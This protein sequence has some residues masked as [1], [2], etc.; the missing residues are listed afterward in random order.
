MRVSWAGARP[1]AVRL[2]CW[3][4][5]AALAAGVFRAIARAEGL[6]P[7]AKGMAAAAAVTLLLSLVIP[8]LSIVHALPG[9]SG[10]MEDLGRWGRETGGGL[11]GS[12]LGIAAFALLSSRAAIPAALAS[13]VVIGAAAV[14]F[15]ALARALGKLVR[16]R[17]AAGCAS[18]AALLAL[19][20]VPFWSGSLLR[21]SA[22][23]AWGKWL[24]GASPYLAAAL[25][26]TQGSVWTYDPRLGA[27]YDTW[28]GTDVPLAYPAWV[29]CAI[30]HLLAGGLLLTA[31][32]LP[33]LVRARLAS[34]SPTA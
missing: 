21:T 34:R 31:A 32:E 19:E 6:S 13:L 10:P 18:A 16:S 27:L 14:S 23:N 5:G 11:A 12:A 15:G 1:L 22:G 29:S 24:V 7:G 4:A 8:A 28:I 2:A 17:L 20:A 33:R 3:A 9:T 30:G 26:W 25:P